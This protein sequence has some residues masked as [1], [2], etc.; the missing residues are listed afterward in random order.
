MSYLWERLS[1]HPAIIDTNKAIEHISYQKWEA[2]AASN[3]ELT[4]D[5]LRKYFPS[6][7]QFVPLP[8][9]P[10]PVWVHNEATRATPGGI[11]GIIG[12][13]ASGKDTIVN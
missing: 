13:S 3:I 11:I 9:L 2:I 7:G 1:R 4:P 6:Y 10:T 12:P 5:N 8:D